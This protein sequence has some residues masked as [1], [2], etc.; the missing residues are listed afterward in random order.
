MVSEGWLGEM[1]YLSP[2]A[3]TN[4][5]ASDNIELFCRPSG[6]QSLNE[7]V[8]RA[9]LP[10]KAPGE[11]PFCLFQLPVAP[12][13]TWLPFVPSPPL[14]LTRTLVPGAIR[15]IQDAL[16]SKLLMTATKTLFPIRPH[17]E[18]LDVNVSFGGHQ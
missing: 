10:L 7:G 17:S 1:A 12:D 5:V 15:V 2:V 13:V 9:T 8:G 3:A 6:S 11:E 16:I 14:S 18:V 4:G